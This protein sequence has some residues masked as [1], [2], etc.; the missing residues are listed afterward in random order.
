M[1]RKTL[2]GEPAEPIT[3]LMPSDLAAKLKAWAAEERRSVSQQMTIAIE[4][5]LRQREAEK[6][7]AA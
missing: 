5:G 2:R 4:D 1:V 6:E 7:A 3:V